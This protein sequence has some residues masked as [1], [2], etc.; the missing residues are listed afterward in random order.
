MRHVNTPLDCVLW[1]IS[2]RNQR[3]L[4][5]RKYSTPL[6]LQP[7]APLPQLEFFFFFL[8]R[9]L[10]FHFFLLH[11]RALRVRQ[12]PWSQRPRVDVTSSPPCRA[13]TNRSD[14]LPASPC[15]PCTVLRLLPH[16]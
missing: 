13:A 1:Q 12:A 2:T 14:D 6:A 7:H 5:E 9:A 16:I 15:I 8:R 4:C 10:L 11:F 3:N